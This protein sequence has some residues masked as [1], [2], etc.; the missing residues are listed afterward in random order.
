[1]KLV[2]LGTAA[3]C[4]TP[5]RGLP[6]VCLVTDQGEV[7][8]FDAGEGAQVAYTRAGLGW[9]KPMK[10]LVTH[11]HGDHCL[12]IPGLLLSMNMHGRSEPVEICG[13]AGIGA[14]V[15]ANAEALGLKP[16]FRVAVNEVGEG[17]GVAAGRGY[18]V[19]ACRADHTVPALSYLFAE[20][21]RPGVFFPGR[22]E[23]LGVPRGPFWHRLQHGQAVEGFGGRIVRPDEVL[24]GGRA[25]RSVGYSGDTRPAGR[26]AEFF[27]GADCLVFDSTFADN[28]AG[29]A[30]ETGHSTAS[31]AARLASKAGVRH[32][33]LTHFSSRYPDTSVMVKEARQHHGSVAAAHDLMEVEIEWPDRA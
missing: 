19:H 24:G 32:L 31:G 8:M 3:A 26:L 23:Q 13:P 4:P 28:H 9:N 18:T 15:R 2:F 12:G 29:R 17:K 25:G 27:C 22:A 14:Y 20:D 21:C 1:M 7:V 30:D 6:C 16:A 5:G 11:M 33:V 10:I